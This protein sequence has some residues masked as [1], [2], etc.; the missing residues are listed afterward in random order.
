SFGKGEAESGDQ[1]ESP[2]GGMEFRARVEGEIDVA[3]RDEGPYR[4]VRVLDLVPQGIYEIFEVVF[5]RF[6][7]EDAGQGGDDQGRSGGKDV[8]VAQAVQRR[9]RIVRKR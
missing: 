4:A 3:A 7:D 9:E 6:G 2:L 8:G 1:E 5:G